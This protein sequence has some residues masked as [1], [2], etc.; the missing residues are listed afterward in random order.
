[1]RPYITKFRLGKHVSVDIDSI[2]NSIPA[3]SFV[4]SD[5]DIPSYY[6]SNTAWII[7]CED[8]D[9]TNV[10]PQD[11]ALRLA[12]I[13]PDRT[14]SS[15][16]VFL[17]RTSSANY[18]CMGI[19]EHLPSE[20]R[21]A[22]DHQRHILVKTYTAFSVCKEMGITHINTSGT[23][24]GDEIE[25]E[26]VALQLLSASLAGIRSIRFHKCYAPSLLRMAFAAA[27][28]YTPTPRNFI[29]H[30]GLDTLVAQWYTSISKVSASL[31]FERASMRNDMKTM[32]EMLDGNWLD[33]NA[34]DNDLICMVAE[35]RSVSGTRLLLEDGRADPSVHNSNSLDCAVGGGNLEVVRLLLDDPRVDPT[36][37]YAL[38]IAAEEGFTDIVEEL[39]EDGRARPDLRNSRALMRAAEKNHPAVVR[40]LL[41]DTRANP[42]DEDS[43]VLY[44]AVESDNPDILRMLLKDGR[45]R[46]D[47]IGGWDAYSLADDM[48]N[49]NML[50][51]FNEDGRVHQAEEGG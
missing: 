32:R 16:E 1:M 27:Y 37:S 39:L 3:F 28:F 4:D 31:A 25:H 33:P 9:V 50:A 18:L 46:P 6:Q 34:N 36:N 23:L 42:R 26:M 8:L 47:D 13:A 38:I 14:M 35:N 45:A 2:T 44:Y 5:Y 49:E 29:N 30:F 22:M 40:L 11:E 48:G 20:W 15:D 10:E 7:P 17:A 24:G 12:E 41:D 51:L 43:A 19:D 21:L